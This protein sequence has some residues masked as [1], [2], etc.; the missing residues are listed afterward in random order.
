VHLEGGIA[1]VHVCANTDWSLVLNSSVDIVNFDAYSYFD[2]F[3]LYADDI[4]RFVNR[5]GIIAWGIIPTSSADDIEKESV[6]TL[7]DKWKDQAGQLEAIIGIDASVVRRQSF[8]TPS[9]GTGSL[10]LDLME[11]VLKLTKGVSEVLRN[12]L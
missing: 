10:S 1:G 11:K 6:G 3:V 12:E 7:V 4:K 8:I 2:R 5:G 9:C